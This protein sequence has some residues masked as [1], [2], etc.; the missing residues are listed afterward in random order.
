MDMKWKGAEVE[1]AI[2]AEAIKRLDMACIFLVGEV[3]KEISIGFPPPSAPGQPPH[4][5][6]GIYRSSIT[7]ETNDIGAQGKYQNE[8]GDLVPYSGSKVQSKD[9]EGHVGTNTFYGP[10]L[11]LGTSKMSPRPHLVPVLEKNRKAI[12]GYFK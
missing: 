7:F 12:A 3:K 1:K 2:R 9:P 11:E 6:T 5:R 10:Y 4:V 8:S